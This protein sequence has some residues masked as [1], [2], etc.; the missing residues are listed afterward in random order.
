M[1]ITQYA[2]GA[3]FRWVANSFVRAVD[4]SEDVKARICAEAP[5]R[6][7]KLLKLYLTGKHLQNQPLLM[8]VQS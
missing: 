7:N 8:S 4:T 6:F 2:V 1:C 5:D 3:L